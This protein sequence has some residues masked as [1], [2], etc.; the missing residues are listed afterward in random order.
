VNI[1]DSNVEAAID[2]IGRYRKD[3][4][5]GAATED[6]AVLARTNAELN[7]FETACII[8]EIPY[9]RRGGRGFL[10]APE[11]KAVLGY[12]DLA[13]GN[14]Y[15]K[16]KGSLMAILTK[17]DRG[18]RLSQNDLEKAVGEALDEV[19]RR[20]RVDVRNIRPDILLDPRNVRI[21]ADRLKQPYR[22]AIIEAMVRK[23]KSRSTAE[24]TYGRIVDD[25][26]DALRE[27]APGLRDLREYI[28][29]DH[30]T[31]ELL[32]HI[33][34]N[35]TSTVKGWDPA[36]RTETFDTST[37]REQI[38]EDTSLYSDDEQDV[39]EEDDKETDVHEE[40]GEEGLLK[41]KPKS[42]QGKGLGAVQ[43]LF[44]LAKPNE[45]DQ[46][47]ATDP[48]MA[49]GYIKKLARYSKLAATLRID[50]SK[51]EKKQQELPPGLRKEKPPAI[52]LST[53]HSVKGAQ[54]QNVAVVMPK[55]LFP[56]ERKPKPDE[57]P[58]DPV[59][60]AARMKA[61]RNLAYVALTRAAV[62]LE[63][64]CPK[65]M[66][67]FV[68]DAGLVIGENVAKPGAEPQDVTKESSVDL[69]DPV[70]PEEF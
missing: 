35:T 62:N 65:G 28:E 16:M 43:F 27:I 42:N 30:T 50:P 68:F 46:K 8:N 6:F 24:Y 55:G 69:L 45:N 2:T 3:I 14:D 5:E 17:P 51:W 15:E 20:E 33:L 47:E 70:H 66:S 48:S 64:T 32:N 1:P 29:G 4:D 67:P 38:S 23:G 56:M 53:V 10:E 18:V 34:D 40:L 12:I 7:D 54:W 52:T 39:E 59:K 41:V 13:T 9:I 49:S 61:E 44:S 26:A 25:L 21:L 57:P 63:V 58:P 36:T 19:A 11:S 22:L 37:L 31:E 60:E